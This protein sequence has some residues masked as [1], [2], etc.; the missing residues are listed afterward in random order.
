MVVQDRAN[1]PAFCGS[2]G[3][4]DGGSKVFCNKDENVLVETWSS[5][6]SRDASIWMVRRIDILEDMTLAVVPARSVTVSTNSA[7]APTTSMRV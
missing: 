7:V 6:R 2:P 4:R 5:I 1:V 3:H